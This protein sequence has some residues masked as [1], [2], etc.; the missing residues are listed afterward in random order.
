MLDDVRQRRDHLMS[1][2]RSE[3]KKDLL[4]HWEPNEGFRHQRLTN[5]AKRALA[6]SSKYTG[7]SATFMKIKSKSLDR[8]AILV[9]TFKYT[10]ML[11]ENKERFVDQRSQDYYRL[12]AT[13]Q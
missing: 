1:W 13:T 8:E 12:D 11:K 4:V 9:E 5:R 2:L 3:I 7:G 10:H 6:R